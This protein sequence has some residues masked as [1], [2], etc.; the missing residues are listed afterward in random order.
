MEEL[1]LSNF[2]AFKS[3]LTLKCDKLNTLVYGEN[4]A[5]KSSIYEAVKLY[6]FTDRIVQ[7][8]LKPNVVGEDR[9]AEENRI[10]EEY[11][12]KANP[13]QNF[14]LTVDGVPYD[15]HQSS[16][17]E[18]FL[19]SYKDIQGNGIDQININSLVRGCYFLSMNAW[20]DEY[21]QMILEEV[22]RVVQNDFRYPEVKIELIEGEG[23]LCRVSWEGKVTP[24]SN[25][26][27]HYFNESVLHM[28]R[29]AILIECMNALRTP[30]KEA[31]L[32]M[33][34]CFNSIDMPN[35]SF[36]IKYLLS[37]TAPKK[38]GKNKGIG[39]QKIIFTHSVTLFNLYKHVCRINE[40]TLCQT[41]S[42]YK[43]KGEY[44]LLEVEKETV[45][46]LSSKELNTEERGN[47]I[48]R[49][50]EYLI[51]RFT[52]LTQ[53]GRKEETNQMLDQIISQKHI[54]LSSN[55]H[56]I[57]NSNDLLSELVATIN[58][59]IECNLKKRLQD[60]IQGYQNHPVNDMLI[61]ILIDLRLMQKIALHPASHGGY[62]DLPPF[63]NKKIDFALDLLEQFED[64]VKAL[65]NM[66]DV[67]TL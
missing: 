30:N 63:S 49:R 13:L 52:E 32:V 19:I 14:T 67:S 23:G 48:R 20:M 2:K 56:Q 53:I 24:Q 58:S 31:L 40:N 28:I 65:E 39:I 37:S 22:N 26:L 18:V 54:Y 11:I 50:F 17:K 4:G 38:S 46:D 41:Y 15:S 33:D 7:E 9:K 47:A 29:F 44:K 12:H 42:L 57:K 66:V 60:K 3:E 25:R 62:E 5:G 6:Y 36:L 16:D 10:I 55:G 64:T 35:R 21:S 27:S 45:K 61:S 51:A 59:P 43:E 34:D 8:Q 1:K